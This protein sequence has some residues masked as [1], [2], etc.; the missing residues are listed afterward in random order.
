VGGG[1]E[2]GESVDETH[3]TGDYAGDYTG[4]Y[5]V[6][7]PSY[8]GDSTGEH[9]EGGGDASVHRRYITYIV[10]YKAIFDFVFRLSGRWI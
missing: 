3:G 2:Q 5:T 10:I 6:E 9:P 1:G 4:D 7:H 8:A